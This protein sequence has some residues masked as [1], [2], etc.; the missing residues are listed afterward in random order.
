ME[1]YLFLGDFVVSASAVDHVSNQTL[2]GSDKLAFML[3]AKLER[4]REPYDGDFKAGDGARL[5][6]T[7]GGYA[8]KVI[9]RFPEELLALNP[10]LNQVYVYDFPEAIKTEVYEFN[11][12]LGTLPGN[13]VIEIEAWKNGEKLTEE[14]Q[15]PVRTD[16]SITEELRT[17]IRD[18]GV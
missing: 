18:N 8:D 9:I 4:S 16:G 17:R 7:T 3:E 6:V 14:L 10:D 1:D 12:P 11:L 13:Y 15:L 2:S 5:T